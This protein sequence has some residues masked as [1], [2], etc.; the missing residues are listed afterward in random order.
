[1]GLP[2]QL[3]QEVNDVFRQQEQLPSDSFRYQQN[4]NLLAKKLMLALKS[5]MQ[6]CVRYWVGKYRIDMSDA[7]S[8]VSESLLFAIDNFEIS[9]GKCKFMSFFWTV[10]SQIFKNHLSKIYAQK[11]MPQVL[12]G[13]DS[14]I[15][16][17]DSNQKA[18]FSKLYSLSKPIDDDEKSTT[19]ENVIGD[20]TSSENYL[21]Y[22]LLVEKIY[23]EATPK[24][25]RVLKRLYFGRSYSEAG[26]KIG[27]SP[28]DICNLVKKIREKHSDLQNSL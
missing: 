4:R 22:K 23:K 10:N 2:K 26:K 17:E 19:L 25:K 24:Q 28:S 14:I 20:K 18:L 11:R 8:L 9:R 13:L 15:N 7:E 12:V 6:S 5:A 3:E 1:M 27:L 16:P 21:H